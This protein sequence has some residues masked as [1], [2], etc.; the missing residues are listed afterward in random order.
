MEWLTKL[1]KR[2]TPKETISSSKVCYQVVCSSCHVTVMPRKGCGPVGLFAVGLAKTMGA[3]KMWVWNKIV[4]SA[5]VSGTKQRTHT[6]RPISYREVC[7]PLYWGWKLKFG[8]LTDVLYFHWP[9]LHCTDLINTCSMATDI[10]SER[11]DLAKK[12]GADVIINCKSE[13]LRERG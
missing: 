1:W 13:N 5:K 12:L 6:W 3:T 7:G 9:L 4:D 10:V 2:L 11:L 8:A